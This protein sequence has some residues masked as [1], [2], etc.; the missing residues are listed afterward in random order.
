MSFSSAAEGL[1]VAVRL[2]TLPLRGSGLW[3]VLPGHAKLPI[4]DGRVSLQLHLEP[5]CRAELRACWP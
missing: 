2:E 5:P 3:R 1:R 4:L